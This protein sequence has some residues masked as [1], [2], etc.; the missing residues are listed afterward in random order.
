MAPEYEECS[1][2][3]P[4]ARVIVMRV[5]EQQQQQQQE[6]EARGVEAAFGEETIDL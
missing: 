4:A 6:A 1:P 5:T 3:S 2:F